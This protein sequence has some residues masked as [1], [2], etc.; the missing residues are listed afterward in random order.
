MPR[1]AERVRS[2]LLPASPP[3]SARPRL[4]ADGRA[5]EQAVTGLLCR[6]GLPSLAA[7]RDH[8][9]I[10]RRFANGRVAREGWGTPPRVSR[11]PRMGPK[12]STATVSWLPTTYTWSK[13]SSG[14]HSLLV[15]PTSSRLA[16]R[17]VTAALPLIQQ[18]DTTISDCCNRRGAALPGPGH[19]SRA[20]RVIVVA[21]VL[22]RWHRHSRNSRLAAGDGATICA[23]ER[24]RNPKDHRTHAGRSAHGP[25]LTLRGELDV[26]GEWS[27]RA[28]SGVLVDQAVEPSC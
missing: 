8:R 20:R 11:L 1:R 6:R 13:R 23:A 12:A 15:S 21:Q 26:L 19:S 16:R 7:R 2:R 22:L 17:R 9:P 4:P 25:L 24:V 10:R 14:L 3:R 5:S 28:G 27:T 18:S